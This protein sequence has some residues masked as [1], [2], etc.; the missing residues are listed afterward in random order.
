MRKLAAMLCMLSIWGINAQDGFTE[1]HFQ[2]LTSF[3]EPTANWVTVKSV[4]M[5]PE[6]DSSIPVKGYTKKEIRTRK[7]K[8][9]PLTPP[10]ALT[11]TDGKGIL[12]QSK[13]TNTSKPLQTKWNH[14]DLELDL[15]FMLA[16]GTK[17]ALLLQ[18]RY[19]IQLTESWGNA[20]AGATDL[21]GILFCNKPLLGKAPRTN[22]SK[23]PGLWQ[24]LKID[25]RAPKF[26]SSGTKIADAK[27][28]S[29][30]LNGALIHSNIILASPSTAALSQTEVISAPIVISGESGSLAIKT[31]RYKN[32]QPTTSSLE[33]ISYKVYKGRI[34][35]V[36]ALADETP[37]K[38]GTTNEI[39]IKLAGIQ[40][41]Y[42]IQFKA[43]LDIKE[44]GTYT[45]KSEFHGDAQVLV[46]GQQLENSGWGEVSGVQ[47]LEAGK[48]TVEIFNAKSRSRHNPKLGF[49]VSSEKSLPKA[50]HA[51]NS[52]PLASFES[53]GPIFIKIGNKPKLVRAFYDYKDESKQ[54]ITHSVVVGDPKNIHYVYDLK[55]GS[56]VCVW[57]GPF[58]NASPMWDGRGNGTYDILGARQHLYASAAIISD[59][60]KNTIL[61]K[62]YSVDANTGLPTFKYTYN[63]TAVSDKILADT[64]GTAFTR[65]I[66]VSN[67]NSE[68]RFKLA[69]GSEITK[70][71]NGTYSIDQAYYISP[72]NGTQVHISELDGKKVLLA[73]FGANP[74]KYELKW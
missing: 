47:K 6:T 73:N 25:F 52:V 13:F 30:H 71:E 18:G 42:A 70:L 62:G 4:S 69:E 56:M 1:D 10:Q 72:K 59:S 2:D 39:S 50:L 65:E 31:L 36:D 40:N 49:W 43:D 7:K 35:N 14:G 66:S 15:E 60:D 26:N 51:A 33:N 58:I 57:K 22:A 68:M 28:V 63:G 61:P 48:Y 46:N 53:D 67:P 55:K 34:R 27:I 23:A 32:F 11:L 64:N 8:N 74:I 17:A 38:E 12:V 41:N 45:F 37:T 16:K 21:G 44:T 29:M 9:L 19:Q 20:Q 54:R 3:Q 24:S 5:D